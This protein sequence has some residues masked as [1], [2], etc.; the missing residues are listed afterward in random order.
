MHFICCTVSSPHE[1]MIPYIVHFVSRYGFLD[2]LQIS[3]YWRSVEA[4]K[5]SENDNVQGRKGRGFITLKFQRAYFL[6][7]AWLY[8]G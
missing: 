3:R 7:A 8:D 1:L 6:G 2:L 4:G 5:S